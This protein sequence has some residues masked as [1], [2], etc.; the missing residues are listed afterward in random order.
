MKRFPLLSIL[1]IT[2]MAFGT[3]AAM[4]TEKKAVKVEVSSV[5]QS[6]LATA[7]ISEEFYFGYVAEATGESIVYEKPP[8]VI[9]EI[10]D[11]YA[12]SII[13]PPIKNNTDLLPDIRRLSCKRHS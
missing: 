5:E 7:L 6:Q 9:G 4:P 10:L 1:A 8:T 3:V 12:T 2:V 11:A 13:K